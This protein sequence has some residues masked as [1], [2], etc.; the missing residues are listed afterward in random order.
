MQD[1]ALDRDRQPFPMFRIFCHNR[2]IGNYG[3]A[4]KAAAQDG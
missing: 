2:N 4:V 3:T 1:E